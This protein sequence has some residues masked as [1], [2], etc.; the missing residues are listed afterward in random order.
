ML[1]TLKQRTLQQNIAW[2][3]LIGGAIG[4]LCAGILTSHE[5]SQLANPSYQPECNLNP[6]FSCTSVTDSN[7]AKAFGFPN[8]FLGMIGFAVIA[9]IGASLLAGAKFK[10][11]FWLSTLAGATFALIFVHW[12]IF[13]ALYTIGALC[14]YCMVVWAVTLPVFWYTLVYLLKEKVIKLPNSYQ[15]IRNFIISHHFDILVVWYLVIIALILKRFWYYW[16]TLI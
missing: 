15:K 2:I 11:W 3:L 10:R 4:V 9:T 13:Q 5:M 6:I 12:L 7:Q 16:S 14:L 1:E 8:P